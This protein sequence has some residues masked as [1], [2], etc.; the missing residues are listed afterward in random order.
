MENHLADVSDPCKEALGK[1]AAGN[2]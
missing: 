2:K 1:A